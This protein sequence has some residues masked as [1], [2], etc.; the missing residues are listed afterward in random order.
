M[1]GK[2]GG[3][4]GRLSS[5]GSSSRALDFVLLLLPIFSYCSSILSKR[6]TSIAHLCKEVLQK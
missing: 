5:S 6:G 4:E 1:Q 3:G 2:V